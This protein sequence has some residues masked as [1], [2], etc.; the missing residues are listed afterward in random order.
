MYRVVHA[1]QTSYTKCFEF[2]YYTL[3]YSLSVVKLLIYVLK[4]FINFIINTDNLVLYVLA[5]FKKKSVYLCRYFFLL[6]SWLVY[7]FDSFQPF[8][9]DLLEIGKCFDSFQPI[10]HLVSSFV[11][12]KLFQTV[13]IRANSVQKERS[14]DEKVWK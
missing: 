13:G 1:E 12:E 11:L 7:C 4:S 5:G 14:G 9:V 10:F 2:Y 3:M 8:F 6:E